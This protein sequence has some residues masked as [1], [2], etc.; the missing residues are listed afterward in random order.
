[1]QEWVPARGEALSQRS[2]G[3]RADSLYPTWLLPHPLRL[4]VRAEV[5]QYQGPLRRLTRLYRV[6][7]GWWEEGGPA[8]RDYFIARSEQAGLVWI[9]RERPA[10]FGESRWYLQG[11]YA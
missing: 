1:M 9:F 3:S 10:A 2:R 8:M 6:E 11:L 7:T 5:P 4:E